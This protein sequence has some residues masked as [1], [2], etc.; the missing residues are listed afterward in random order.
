[1]VLILH[2]KALERHEAQCLHVLILLS[3]PLVLIYASG[4]AFSWGTPSIKLAIARR[5]L[6]HFQLG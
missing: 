1:M 6:T 5:L 3:R 2:S 4:A